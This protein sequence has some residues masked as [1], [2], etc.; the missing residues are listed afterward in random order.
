MYITQPLCHRQNE[1]Q[2]HLLNGVSRFKYKTV[3]LN[4]RKYDANI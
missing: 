4:T 2:G 3:Q 1:T